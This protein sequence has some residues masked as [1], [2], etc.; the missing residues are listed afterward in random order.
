MELPKPPWSW[1]KSAWLPERVPDP[2]TVRHTKWPAAFSLN[3]GQL[4]TQGTPQLCTVSSTVCHRLHTAH[5]DF[6][7]AALKA[8]LFPWETCR[9]KRSSS[10]VSP[11]GLPRFS[12]QLCGHGVLAYHPFPP[13]PARQSGR[14]PARA[15]LFGG[16]PFS[17]LLG[18]S[19]SSYQLSPLQAL[20]APVSVHRAQLISPQPQLNQGAPLTPPALTADCQAAQALPIPVSPNPA[21]PWAQDLPRRE[22]F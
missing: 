12:S 19:G 21:P 1:G 15:F 13:S 18:R 22:P 8:F 9:N 6:S 17:L 5:S 2:C 16:S 4:G 14:R 3:T 10:N 7:N 11:W 20:H